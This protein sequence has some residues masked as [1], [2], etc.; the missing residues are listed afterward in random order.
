MMQVLARRAIIWLYGQK[1]VT[2]PDPGSG[3]PEGYTM[4]H[5]TVPLDLTSGSGFATGQNM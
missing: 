1:P 4:W 2:N 3:L 5:C